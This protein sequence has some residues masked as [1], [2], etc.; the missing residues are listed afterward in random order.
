MTKIIFFPPADRNI[1]TVRT[2]PA[3]RVS[4]SFSFIFPPSKLSYQRMYICTSRKSGKGRQ[5]I[6]FMQSIEDILVRKPGSCKEPSYSSR[7]LHKNRDMLVNESFC[8]SR[9]WM[10][11]ILV[12][13]D[14]RRG[15]ETRGPR[16]RLDS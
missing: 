15:R 2:T 6:F 8:D 7:I 14:R 1:R 16:K 11:N 5:R 10:R 3:N 13:I 9:Y 4:S 12:V